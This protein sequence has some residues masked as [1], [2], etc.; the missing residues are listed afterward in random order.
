LA[1]S[2]H[3]VFFGLINGT[4]KD[5]Y[6]AEGTLEGGDGEGGEGGDN[7]PAD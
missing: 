2:R 3:T 4:E 5:Y 6:V 1:R 7:K